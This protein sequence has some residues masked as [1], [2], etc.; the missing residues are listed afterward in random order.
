TAENPPNGAMIDY[1]LKSP[2]SNVTLEL[3][4]AQQRLVRRFSSEEQSATKHV[5]LP[6]AERWFPKP[7]IVQKTPG[8]HRLVWDLTW[9]SSGGPIADE[10]AA[11]R[12]PS[13]PKAAP[14]LYQVRLAVDGQVQTQTLQ[15][16][17]DPRSPATPE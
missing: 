17:M 9:G 16:I 2:A 6:V 1:F 12:N 13:G 5:S 11:S 7:E 3:W 4:D 8:M 15:V 14:G 10:E